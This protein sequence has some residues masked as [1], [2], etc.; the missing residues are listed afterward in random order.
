R[1]CELL[2]GANDVCTGKIA[3]IDYPHRHVPEPSYGCELGDVAGALP[4]WIRDRRF[5]RRGAVSAELTNTKCLDPPSTFARFR[6]TSVAV[7][8]AMWASRRE[9]AL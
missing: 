3:S 7:K 2:R 6:T 4:T 9:S 8:N 1:P 5:E